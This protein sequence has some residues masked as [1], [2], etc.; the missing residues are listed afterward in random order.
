MLSLPPAPKEKEVGM[1]LFEWNSFMWTK[2]TIFKNENHII[3]SLFMGQG[4]ENHLP[5]ESASFSLGHT[6]FRN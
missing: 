3:S 5:V 1:I 2:Q 4:I 6:C